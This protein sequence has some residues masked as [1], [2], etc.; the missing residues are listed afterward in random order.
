MADDLN[1]AAVA[2]ERYPSD[3]L[4]TGGATAKLDAFVAG[5]RWALAA[6]RDG[7]RAAPTVTTEQVEHIV[8]ALVAFARDEV[9]EGMSVEEYHQRV[10]REVLADLG[11]EVREP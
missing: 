3:F 7:E 10:V 9:S 4:T 2:A 8:S 5:A 11:I 1:S 6:A